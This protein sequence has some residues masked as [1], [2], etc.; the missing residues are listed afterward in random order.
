M[1]TSRRGSRRACTERQR[2]RRYVD[3]SLLK[4]EQRFF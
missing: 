2:W 4:G 1:N 3:T